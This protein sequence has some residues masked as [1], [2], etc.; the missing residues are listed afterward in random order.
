MKRKKLTL[1]KKVITTLSSNEMGKIRG[2]VLYT[3]SNSDCTHF[4]CCQSQ[5]GCAETENREDT[6]CD[7][8]SNYISGCANTCEPSINVC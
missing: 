2:G 6:K 4:L 5:C 8:P 1:N 3:T 7:F